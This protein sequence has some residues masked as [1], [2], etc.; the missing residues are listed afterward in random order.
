MFVQ[1]NV[2]STSYLHRLFAL[3]HGFVI[4]LVVRLAQCLVRALLINATR[5]QVFEVSGMVR[6]S[7]ARFSPGMPVVGHG[8]LVLIKKLTILDEYDGN[9]SV[10]VDDRTQLLMTTIGVPARHCQ[11]TT[12]FGFLHSNMSVMVPSSTT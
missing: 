12:A 3:F 11:I 6:W 4:Y 2:H 9:I 10:G 7:P 5:V 8:Y 1:Y